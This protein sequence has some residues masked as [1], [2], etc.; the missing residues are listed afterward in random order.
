LCAGSHGSAREVMG[1]FG[2]SERLPVKKHTKLVLY[3]PHSL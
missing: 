1:P 2:L 3:A